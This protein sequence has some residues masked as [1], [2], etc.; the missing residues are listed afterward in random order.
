ME[1][2]IV[3]GGDIEAEHDTETGATAF[4]RHSVKG[5]AVRIKCKPP[6]RLVTRWLSERI[7]W[8]II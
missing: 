3:S 7:N 5:G 1:G 6:V 2:L 8:L 4:A